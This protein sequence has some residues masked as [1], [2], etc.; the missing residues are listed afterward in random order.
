MK[1]AI[2]AMSDFIEKKRNLSP[3]QIQSMST[4]LKN[5]GVTN[6][7]EEAAKQLQILQRKYK[8]K[9]AII[10]FAKKME[11]RGGGK[12]SN[13]KL[14]GSIFDNCD[15]L[16]ETAQRELIKSD[17]E[18]SFFKALPDETIDVLRKKIR[19]PIN[20][21]GVFI[22]PSTTDN[23]YNSSTSVNRNRRH[24]INLNILGEEL[25]S[26][27]RERF[28]SVKKDIPAGKLVGRNGYIS[29][30]ASSPAAL[31]H[32]G[33]HAFNTINFTP[34]QMRVLSRREG[35]NDRK[36]E[37]ILDKDRDLGLRNMARKR[38]NSLSTLREELQA[39]TRGYKNLKK[40]VDS[41]D[42]P[43]MSEKGKENI[44]KSSANE[45]TRSFNT[46]STD[47]ALNLELD[48]L[49]LTDYFINRKR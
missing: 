37:N 26:S 35:V 44:L 22:F 20:K 13:P 40:I 17:Y 36:I 4:L 29:V 8:N 7:E 39:S 27:V 48:K 25:P 5:A 43:Y 31:V 42:L 14:I 33:G 3:Q 41:T 47:A 49:R 9:D 2:V 21:R 24:L 28:E 34:K 10:R 19:K 11:K 38:L 18:S 30:D 23:S 1:D 15:N 12:K 45:L 46:Y 6:T 32:E 16:S